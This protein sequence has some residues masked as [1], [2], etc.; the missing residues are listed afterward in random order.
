[1]PRFSP[2]RLNRICSHNTITGGRSV[3]AGERPSAL[4]RLFYARKTVSQH[5]NIKIHFIE[6][7]GVG[8]VVET[9]GAINND[10]SLVV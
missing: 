6:V 7:I 5:G 2:H 3:N 9:V 4:T 1:M 10:E 8:L